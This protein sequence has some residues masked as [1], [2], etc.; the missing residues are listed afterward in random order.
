MTAFQYKNKF[1]N[2]SVNI[3]CLPFLPSIFGGKKSKRREANYV[4]N[5]VG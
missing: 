2:N 5:N 4:T 1:V 3:F